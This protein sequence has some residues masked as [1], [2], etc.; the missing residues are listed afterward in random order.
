MEARTCPQ[1]HPEV[2]QGQAE[3]RTHVP[4][5]TAVER[6]WGKKRCQYRCHRI[7]S[8]DLDNDPAQQAILEIRKLSPC[9]ISEN[10]GAEASKWIK[11]WPTPSPRSFTSIRCLAIHLYSRKT[12]NDRINSHTTNITSSCR[13]MSASSERYLLSSIVAMFYISISKVIYNS[14]GK[15]NL[16]FKKYKLK[17]EIVKIWK[18]VYSLIYTGG[19][20]VDLQL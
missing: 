19:A 9:P 15:V 3:N 11:I 13:N 4:L 6:R 10:M 2:G 14:L 18:R 7:Y 16:L 20:K 12:H 5:T 8:N 17:Q 1:P